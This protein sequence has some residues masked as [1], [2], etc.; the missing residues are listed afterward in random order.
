MPVEVA[1]II[2][3]DVPPSLRLVGTINPDRRSV[4]ASEVSG[5]VA[6]FTADE[7][8]FV[9]P[10]T[11]IC[12][13][14][15]TVAQLAYDEALATLEALQQQL[16]QMLNGERKEDLDRWD[17]LVAEAEAMV[18][19]WEYERTR[20][21]ELVARGQGAD[22]EAHDAEMEFLAAQSRL[23]QAK[24]HLERARNGARA[25][26]LARMRAQVAA[27]QA[28]MKRAARDL[29]R[30]EIRAPFAGAVVAKHT[31]VGAWVATGAAVCELIALDTV[32][33]RTDVPESVIGFATVGAPAT[34]E[35]EALGKSL[36]GTIARVV[37]QADPTARTFP[38]EIDLANKDHKLL[39]GMFVWAQVP[40]GP[41]GK[42]LMVTKDAV[43]ARGLSKTIYVVRPT[44][45]NVFTAFPTAVATGLEL[46][47]EVEVSAQG[48]KAGDVVVSRANERLMDFPMP[49]TPLPAA[50]GPPATP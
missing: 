7:G 3:R 6:A 22:K 26:E 25:E 14:N 41:T 8:T 20:T 28:A 38:V 34:V 39:S 47:G 1:A 30:T 11:V 46:G 21:R 4:I 17:A 10:G 45:E 49:V 37:P 42:R 19:K 43:V 2:E 23:A 13:L 12:R 44:G 24:A 5:L 35:V 50:G 40:A 15:N 31:E 48:L 16:T 32:R 27:Q 33:V 29:N 9:E 36:S 18:K